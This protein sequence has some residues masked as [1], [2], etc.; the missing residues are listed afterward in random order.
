MLSGARIARARAREATR[1]EGS[2]GRH[3][4][5]VVE[6]LSE[7]IHLFGDERLQ[8]FGDPDLVCEPDSRSRGRQQ[9]VGDET[10]ARGA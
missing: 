9:F 10:G 4:D 8:H 1:V 7:S 5:R 6:A 3:N 2:G